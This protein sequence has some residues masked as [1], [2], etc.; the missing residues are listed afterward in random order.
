[1]IDWGF[2]TWKPG[3]L[4]IH[5]FEPLETAYLLNIANKPVKAYRLSDSLPLVVKERTTCEGDSSWT[6]KLPPRSS[7]EIDQ[8][9]CVEVIGDTIEF[10]PIKD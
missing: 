7:E 6:I 4:Y 2:F 9:I 5:I 8:V 3:K 10:E 1:M